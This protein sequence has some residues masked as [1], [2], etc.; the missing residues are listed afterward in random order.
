ME[1]FRASL[2]LSQFIYQAGINLR[3]QITFSRA[4]MKTLP[5]QNVIGSPAA[6][7]APA[8]HPTMMKASSV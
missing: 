5:E 6:C 8:R 3:S 1:N 7:L 4:G 2:Q